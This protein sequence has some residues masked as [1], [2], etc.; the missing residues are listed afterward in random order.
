MFHLQRL[1]CRD[2]SRQCITQ[3]RLNGVWIFALTLVPFTTAWVGKAPDA[4]WPEFLY[5]LNL[6]LWSAAFQWLDYQIR[7]D[8]PGAERDET[9][10][11]PVRIFMYGVYLLCMVLAFVKPV[12]CIY[13]VGIST[14]LMFIWTFIKGKKRKEMKNE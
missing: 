3:Q 7:K 13:L 12:L 14:V 11:L 5:G 4:S 9:T 2:R 8:N 10:R 6:F 1:R